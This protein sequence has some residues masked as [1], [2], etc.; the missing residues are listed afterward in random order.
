L[1]PT[2]ETEQC[3]ILK[4]IA[5]EAKNNG[6]GKA[7]AKLYAKSTF[8]KEVNLI[9]LRQ[10][11]VVESALQREQ[12]KLEKQAGQASSKKHAKKAAAKKSSS[13]ETLLDESTN[14]MESRILLKKQYRK[15]TGKCMNEQEKSY[16][17]SNKKAV[18]ADPM[19]TSL[20]ESDKKKKNSANKEE[21][22]FLKSIEEQE[23][24]PSKDTTDNESE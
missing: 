7:H 1:D 16:Q 4:P 17:K 22:A 3:F 6:N 15:M 21:K 20:D 8:C 10:K 14:N 5:H 24:S 13:N 19:D 9:S 12:G 23:K 18:S 2:H 11:K